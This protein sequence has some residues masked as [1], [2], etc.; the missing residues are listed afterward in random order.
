MNG[1][2]DSTPDGSVVECEDDHNNPYIQSA[3]DTD[4]DV[5][6]I[7]ESPPPLQV[8]TV[9]FIGTTYDTMAQNILCTASELLSQGKEEPVEIKPEPDNPRDA[10]AFC[11]VCKVND[12]WCRI[13]YVVSEAVA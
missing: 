5:D 4:S 13:G 12:K 2:T 8:H 1:D 11:F 7:P 9:R 3:S 6:I 10:K